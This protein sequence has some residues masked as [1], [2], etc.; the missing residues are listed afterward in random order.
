MIECLFYYQVSILA[1]WHD[2]LCPHNHPMKQQPDS[3]VLVPEEETEGQRGP[4]WS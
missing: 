3:L 1:F 2:F 4:V